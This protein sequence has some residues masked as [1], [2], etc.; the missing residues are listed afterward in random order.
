[1]IYKYRIIYKNSIILQELIIRNN[2]EKIL[3]IASNTPKN[4]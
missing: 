4:Q 3:Q 1:V 2:I